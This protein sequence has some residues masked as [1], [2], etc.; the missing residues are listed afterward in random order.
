MSEPNFI[1]K[2]FLCGSP[3]IGPQVSQSGYIF[4]KT[5]QGLPIADIS[6][7]RKIQTLKGTQTSLVYKDLNIIIVV[8]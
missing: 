8:C 5:F 6:Y 4:M 1:L 3:H 2:R 7:Y